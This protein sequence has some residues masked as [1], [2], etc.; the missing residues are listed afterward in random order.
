MLEDLIDRE[1]SCSD[2]PE[3]CPDCHMPIATCEC[4][5]PDAELTVLITAALDLAQRLLQELDPN[6]MLSTEKIRF[7]A[8][9]DEEN[10]HH[11]GRGLTNGQWLNLRQC[12]RLMAQIPITELYQESQQEQSQ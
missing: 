10:S 8:N 7:I 1:C 2:A 12:L 5:K 9:W 4:E 3:L 6:P 11:H